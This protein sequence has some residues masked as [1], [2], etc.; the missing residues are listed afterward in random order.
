M[1]QI[2]LVDENDKEI[3]VMEKME[4]HRKGVLHRA[5]SILIFNSKKELLLQ[6]RSVQKYHS[7]GLWTNTCCSHPEPGEDLITSARKKLM[8]EMGFEVQLKPAYTFAYRASLDNNLTEHEF[9]HVLVG[10]F[11]GEPKPNAQEAEDWTYKSVEN[12]QRDARENPNS[13]TSW[14]KL[15][16]TH[17]QLSQII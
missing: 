2:I 10:S 3:G 9:D 8:H 7:G 15:I 1:D 12:I 5:F 4:A 14:F 11:D 16:L 13:Y 6:K 17:P